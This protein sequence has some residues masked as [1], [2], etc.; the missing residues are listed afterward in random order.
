MASSSA[1]A[2]DRAQS[3]WNMC[4][5]C[6]G[7][8]GEGKED[9]GAP[10][11]AGLP[12]WYVAAQLTKFKNGARAS[13]PRDIAGL[14]MRPMA[15]FLTDEDLPL[16]AKY[17]GTSLPMVSPPETVRGNLV[18][19]ENSYKV[20]VACHGVDGM[21]NQQLGAPPLVGSSDWYLV[22]QLKNFKAA[23][24]GGNPAVDPIGAS[25]QGM[26]ATLADDQAILDVVAYIN[27]L[28]PAKPA[29]H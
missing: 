16:M 3:I 14:R 6:H 8:Q 9:I 5:T 7:A 28:R 4:G 25:M 11:V 21:G 13:H 20:C 17:V 24:R 27:T 1:I 19:G 22:R 10:A 15:R 23:V 12:E 29:G 26:A 18:K 2:R